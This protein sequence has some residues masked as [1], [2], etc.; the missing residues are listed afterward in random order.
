MART[1]RRTKLPQGLGFNLPDPL[2]R[3]IKF[4][5]NLFQRVLPLAADPEP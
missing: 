1:L 3:D 5:P 2:A 4:L